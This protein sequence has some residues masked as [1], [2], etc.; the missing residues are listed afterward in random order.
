MQ[1]WDGCVVYDADFLFINVVAN[2]PGSVHDPRVLRLS[3]LFETFEGNQRPLQGIILGENSSESESTSSSSESESDD[4]MDEDNNP[5]DATERGRTAAERGWGESDE[6]GEDEDVVGGG[7]E[8]ERGEDE[9]GGE[10]D[11]GEDEDGGEGKDDCEDEGGD[12]EGAGGEDE[13][14]RHFGGN[15]WSESSMSSSCTA[16]HFTAFYNTHG[17]IETPVR[18]NTYRDAAKGRL[19]TRHRV[20]QG[21]T[22]RKS[23]AGVRTTLEVYSQ[24]DGKKSRLPTKIGQQQKKRFNNRLCAEGHYTRPSRPNPGQKWRLGLGSHTSATRI[25]FPKSYGSHPTVNRVPRAAGIQGP[26]L[27]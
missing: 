7:D 10:D 5:S 22:A 27:A 21:D 12:G 11:G 1:K 13:D 19:P 2:W 3:P 25:P 24:S 23:L 16:V 18:L 4:D 8:D 15:E 14:E 17:S 26:F 9:D 6:V 20:Q